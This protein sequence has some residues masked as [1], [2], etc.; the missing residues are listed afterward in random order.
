MSERI[1]LTTPSGRLQIVKARIVAISEIG[2]TDISHGAK[3]HVFVDNDN[4]P[5]FV[6]EDFDHVVG[7]L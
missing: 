3:T 4:D 7:L 5:F 2:E 1:N 6:I